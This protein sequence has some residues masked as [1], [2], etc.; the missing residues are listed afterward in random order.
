MALLHAV[1]SAHSRIFRIVWTIAVYGYG[2]AI[3]AT[4]E[5]L[6]IICDII[7]ITLSIGPILL[8]NF[9]IFGTVAHA[10]YRKFATGGYGQGKGTV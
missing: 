10:R 6:V 1:R 2:S 4:A 8:A 7:A 9:H 3:T 5:L